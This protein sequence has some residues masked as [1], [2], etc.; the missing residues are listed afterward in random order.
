MILWFY[1]SRHICKIGPTGCIWFIWSSSFAGMCS[2]SLSVILPWWP[3][4]GLHKLKSIAA[5]ASHLL[6]DFSFY[7][8]FCFHS[9]ER[10]TE[11]LNQIHLDHSDCA[12]FE[13]SVWNSFCCLGFNHQGIRWKLQYLRCV[14]CC[15]SLNVCHNNVS[16]IRLLLIL[17][18]YLPSCGLA[19]LTPGRE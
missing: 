17:N 5:L 14:A 1:E 19:W 3:S 2:L 13:N 18:Y 9:Q 16:F 10:E 15:C 12:E 7:F 8:S 4:V 11:G 6:F